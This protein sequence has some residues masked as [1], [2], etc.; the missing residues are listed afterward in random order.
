MNSACTRRPGWGAGKERV[1]RGE[2]ATVIK[3]LELLDL[4]CLDP[5]ETERAAASSGGPAV[6]VTGRHPRFGAPPQPYELGCSRPVVMSRVGMSRSGCPGSGCR[7]RAV[8]TGWPPLLAGPA[9]VH[10][11]VG[12]IAARFRHWSTVRRAQTSRGSESS[13][14][15]PAML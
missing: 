9:L 6:H 1:T 13:A 10:A 8:N 15:W 11:L 2:V 3:L 4:H 12:R 5:Q 14:A 7:G